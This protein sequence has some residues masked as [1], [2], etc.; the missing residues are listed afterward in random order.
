MV[1]SVRQLFQSP[2]QSVPH[3]HVGLPD[4]PYFYRISHIS[5]RT[6]A[7]KMLRELSCYALRN[8]SISLSSLCSVTRPPCFTP[9]QNS[10]ARIFL[11]VRSGISKR[12][13]QIRRLASMGPMPRLT[14][15][16]S[17]V[18]WTWSRN[19]CTS[20]TCLRLIS[21]SRHTCS[22]AY[23]KE[24]DTRSLVLPKSF[25]PHSTVTSCIANGDK[26]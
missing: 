7:V 18:S 13:S 1:H 23:V 14:R 25:K 8:S 21:A 4:L 26:Q 3:I 20:S 24:H 5:D 15:W 9:S 12:R 6:N 22:H 17:N 10:L 11:C 19:C 2:Y 16:S